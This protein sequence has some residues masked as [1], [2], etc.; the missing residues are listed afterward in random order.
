MTEL[1]QTYDLYGD[2]A[3]ARIKI[4]E[5]TS[6]LVCENIKGFLPVKLAPILSYAAQNT[7]INLE[8]ACGLSMD[9][10]TATRMIKLAKLAGWM[11]DAN[12]DGRA[13]DEETAKRYY[14]TPRGK[15]FVEQFQS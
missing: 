12:Y 6:G 10:D 7:V 9:K 8:Q 2:G 11:R 3:F 13:D 1:L 4:I 15:K 14:I 5:K